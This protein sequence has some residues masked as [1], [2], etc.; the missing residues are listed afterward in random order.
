M[1]KGVTLKHFIQDVVRWFGITEKHIPQD[2]KRL[3]AKI[4]LAFLFVYSLAWIVYIGAYLLFD[5]PLAALMVALLGLPSCAVGFYVFKSRGNAHLASIIAN[6]G[7]LT[8]L[9]GITLATGD[10]Y[11]PIISWIYFGT[12]TSYLTSGARAGLFINA[13]TIL[14]S[15]VLNILEAHGFK[16]AWPWSFGLNS[17]WYFY[18][19]A[20][21]HFCALFSLGCVTL[22]FNALIR[23]SVQEANQAKAQVEGKNKDIQAI[24][25]NISYGIFS[26]GKAGTIEEGYS[27]YLE[28]VVQQSQ[29]VGTDPFALLFRKS[30]LSAESLDQMKNLVD[31]SIGESP[32]VYELNSHLLPNELRITIDGQEKIV[33]CAFDVI[34]DAKGL[35]QKFLVA[36]KDVTEQRGLQWKAKKNQEEM[37]MVAELL[38]LK[39]QRFTILYNSAKTFISENKNLIQRN[40]FPDDE[41]L[42]V[43]FVNLHTVKGNARTLG[44]SKV[45]ALAHEAEHRYGLLRSGERDL[46]EPPKMV[47][48]LNELDDIF[49]LYRK[50]AIEKLNRQDIKNHSE[51]EKSILISRIEKLERH[52]PQ[53]KQENHFYDEILDF[54]CF[55]KKSTG[56]AA[57][58]FLQEVT[59]DVGLI[60][61][62]LGKETPQVSIEAADFTFTDKG[63]DILRGVFV[64]ILRNSLDHGIETSEERKQAGK[65]PAGMIRI[66]MHQE[67]ARFY[68][69]IEDDGRGLDLAKIRS[70]GIKQKL[71]RPTSSPNEV[72]QLIFEA[73]L[74]TATG[75]TE[76]SGRGIG[77]E[78]VRRFMK[79]EG[80]DV[81][82][83]FSADVGPETMF[84][85]FLLRLELPK[86]FLIGTTTPTI[87]IK[88]FKTDWS[89]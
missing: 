35:I 16:F 28:R 31:N 75:V 58:S 77:M 38:N 73:N 33:E 68:I 5:N 67:A 21:T 74:S 20:F 39:H 52:I 30:N 6:F 79:K 89:A 37:D 7:S 23:R 44:L 86:L 61:K 48:E 59:A 41:V 51:I 85:P 43:L 32:L 40:N 45:T 27:G 8:T 54:V 10:G 14:G 76:I 34:L 88:S 17:A 80:G 69:D 42:K 70:I 82:L 55:L 13:Y 15:V 9:F 71:C 26:I 12:I 49:E 65:A 25:K 84:V 29:L 83:I 1:A 64:H 87:A 66:R 19:N 36:V 4:I 62:D 22:I 56:H 11:S 46:W 78:A 60:A 53:F 47:K 24:F 81:Q 72:A 2:H 3:Q 50:I 57:E 63:D 18:F